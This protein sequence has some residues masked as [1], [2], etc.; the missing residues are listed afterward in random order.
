MVQP[1][2]LDS[3]RTIIL[4]GPTAVGKSSL[5][6]ELA[7]KHDLEIINAD[8]VC[9]YQEFNIGS[10]KPTTEELKQVPHHLIDIAHPNENYHAGKFIQDLELALQDIHSRK[11]RALIV[12][13]S[14]FYLK[15]LRLGLWEAPP[16]SPEVRERLALLS[17]TELFSRLDKIDPTHA[18]K[19]GPSDRYRLTRAIE[20]YELSGKTPSE[21]EAQMPTE[22]NPRFELWVVDREKEELSKRMHTRIQ[23]MIDQ[24]LIDEV[25]DLRTRFPDSKTLHA[26]GYQQVLDFLDGVPPQG[27]KV[28]KGMPGLIEEIELAH[29]QLAKQQRTWFK[30]LK[31]NHAFELDQDRASLQEKVMEFYQ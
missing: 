5:A 29:R 18:K 15:A 6:I 1:K 22:P 19:I 2:N 8:S 26:I 28:Q 17:T 4:T 3:P 27:R 20:I 10:A 13:G 23:M 16:T 11:K 14:G 21:L 12:G 24:G 30:S 31:A 9:F 7:M 25:K